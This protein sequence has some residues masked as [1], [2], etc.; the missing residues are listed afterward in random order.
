MN[1]QRN[2][3]QRVERRKKK[4]KKRIIII[5]SILALFIGIAGYYATNLISAF[6]NSHDENL[7]TDAKKVDVKQE[8]FTMLLVGIDQYDL[9]NE[10]KSGGRPDVL[11]VATVNPKEKS[12]RTMSIPRDTYVKFYNSTS[13][14]KITETLSA[15]HSGSDAK[16]KNQQIVKQV[17]QFLDNKIQIN[18]VAQINFSGFMDLVDAVG[19]ITVDN[20]YKFQVPFYGGKLLKYEPGQIKLDG[21]KALMYVRT[22]KEH[23]GTGSRVPPEME[24]D[25]DRNRRQQ[26]VIN[27]ILNK[28]IGFTGVTQFSDITKAVG[29]NFRYSFDMGEVLPLF[30]VYREAQHN[31]ESITLFNYEVRDGKSYQ[32]VPEGERQR[33]IAE[34]LKHLGKD[35]D[36]HALLYD[37]T[38]DPFQA[39]T[40]EQITTQ[41]S[42]RAY[43]NSEGTGSN[44]SNQ[45]NNNQPKQPNGQS[46]HSQNSSNKGN[47]ST[48]TTP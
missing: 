11:M 36:K 25:N 37:H 40:L 26:E 38:L 9:E 23:K 6:S 30:N 48:T 27:L 18:Y 45:P 32:T 43:R 4:K 13:K 39:K 7:K 14:G 20:K 22:R 3:Q 16:A 15:L 33:A 34:L 10:N 24:D 44:Q 35:Y 42:P 12:V 31:K 29:K 5:S 1:S 2:R 21:E 17:E 46:N 28:M 8:P 19:G 47:K 41:I